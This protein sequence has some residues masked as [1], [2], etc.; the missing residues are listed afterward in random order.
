MGSSR[1]V[2]R[3]AEHPGLPTHAR[4]PELLS[5]SDDPAP[6]TTVVLEW[7][8]EVDPM[9]DPAIQ[10]RIATGEFSPL[11]IEALRM[12]AVLAVTRA[13]NRRRILEAAKD[14]R[15]LAPVPELSRTYCWERR[16]G[17]RVEATIRDA[18]V[19]LSSEC[20]HEFVLR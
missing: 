7:V 9:A 4:L 6:K 11:E 14:P 2:G 12:A 1:I 16:N 13:G 5:A 3:L 18:D 20:G 8:G 19:I 17:Y 10:F 15:S